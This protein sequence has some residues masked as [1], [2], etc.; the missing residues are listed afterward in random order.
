MSVMSMVICILSGFLDLGIV[1]VCNVTVSARAL[2][3]VACL[4]RRLVVLLVSDS[5][6]SSFRVK[7]HKGSITVQH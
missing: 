5:F 1:T 2:A 6:N 3:V 4:P 7:S